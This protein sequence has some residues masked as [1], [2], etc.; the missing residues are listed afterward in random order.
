MS[1][2]ELLDL[3]RKP[4]CNI[5]VEDLYIDGQIHP[6]I[7]GLVSNVAPFIVGPAGLTGSTF[8]YNTIQSAI[9]D[10][11]LQNPSDL[12]PQ[13]IYIYQD[14]YQE[15]LTLYGGLHFV[16]LDD[17][18]NGEKQAQE[19]NIGNGISVFNGVTISGNHTFIQSASFSSVIFDNITFDGFNR[20][21]S[22]ISS[23]SSEFYYLVLNNCKVVSYASPQTYCFYLNNSN[24]LQVS[25]NN[26]VLE[27]FSTDIGGSLFGTTGGS[28]GTFIIYGQNSSLVE[29]IGSDFLNVGYIQFYLNSCTAL[30][31]LGFTGSLSQCEL[32][33]TNSSIRGGLYTTGN[34]TLATFYNSTTTAG[35]IELINCYCFPSPFNGEGFTGPLVDIYG[36]SNTFNLILTNCYLP[37]LTSIYNSSHHVPNKY[38]LTNIFSNDFWIDNTNN[39]LYTI[40]NTGSYLVTFDNTLNS[41]N[42]NYYSAGESCNILVGMKKSLAGPSLAQPQVILTYANSGSLISVVMASAQTWT[43]TM[44]AVK[45]GFNCQVIIE[46]GGS[47]GGLLVINGDTG[48]FNGVVVGSSG[49]NTGF[50]YKTILTLSNYTFDQSGSI[51]NITCSEDTGH[52]S[53][54]FSMQ[55]TS[56]WLFV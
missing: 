44:P 27:P 6:P 2:N 37:F 49:T 32:V 28:N 55:N 53:C 46:N 4:W 22:D 43:V 42:Y 18:I 20:V 3:K 56:E 24:T 31:Q 36:A 54:F 39:Y 14:I 45:K 38:Q 8:I 50:L 1:L 5:E 9:N 13:T 17:S 35:S 40:G 11:I 15:D 48:K 47:T 33:A 34:G 41:Y 23:H 30:M 16:G 51:M 26:S 52:Y 10:A 19:Y 21:F 25:L 29:G 12:H 7:S